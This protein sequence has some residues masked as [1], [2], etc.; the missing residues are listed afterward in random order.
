MSKS[1]P[2]EVIARRSSP[3]YIRLRITVQYLGLYLLAFL[4]GILLCSLIDPTILPMPQAE[5]EA[6]FASPF[7]SDCSLLDGAEAIL[8]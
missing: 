8:S 7:P 3:A 2:P 6:H 1:V 4:L 5:I